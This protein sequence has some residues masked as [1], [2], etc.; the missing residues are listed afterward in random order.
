MQA[1]SEMIHSIVVPATLSQ[2]EMLKRYQPLTDFLQVETPEKLYRFR[3]CDERSISAFD[4]DQ[5]WFSLSYKMNDDFD[6]LLHFD[7]ERI[8]SDLKAF[9]ENEQLRLAFR[10]IGEGAKLPAH[11]QSFLP[12]KILETF[13]KNIAQM[14]EP[15]MNASLEQSYDFFANQIDTNNDAIQQVIQKTIKFACFSEAIESAAMWGY[16]ADSSKGFALSYDFRNGGYT[17]CNSCLTGNQC[18]FYK[19]CLLAPVIYGDTCFDATKYA[20]WLFQQQIIIK[21]LSDGNALSFYNFL[22][23]LIPCP[24][25]FMPTKVL[26]HKAST[27]AHEREWRLTCQCNSPEFNQQEFSWAR[28][29][30]TAIYLGRKISPIHEKILRNIATEKNIPVY[31]MQIIQD[32]SSYKLHPQILT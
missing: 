1:Y 8:E 29:K 25:L 30:P 31:K 22:Q 13:R 3:R 24:D 2:E 4:Q 7:R 26:L 11:L 27:W 21:I 18:L 14:D 10:A 6:A 12:S 9:S 32:D 28:K 19:N 20:T 5:L 17:M 15:T 16:Y 23:D